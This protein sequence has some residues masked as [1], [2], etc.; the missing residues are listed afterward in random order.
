MS[1][2]TAKARKDLDGARAAVREHVEKWRRYPGEYDKNFAVKT[3][4]RVQRDI[5]KIKSDHPSLNTNSPEDSW[6]VRNG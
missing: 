6:T 4:E 3:I 5:A 1:D 2:N